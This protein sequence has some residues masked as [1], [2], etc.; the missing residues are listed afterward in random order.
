MKATRVALRTVAAVPA[1]LLVLALRSGGVA[2]AAGPNITIEHTFSGSSTSQ[3]TPTFTGMTNDILDTVTLK[4]YAGANATGSPVQSSTVLPV[5]VRLLARPTEAT[6]TVALGTALRSGQ[7]T[8]LAEQ[9]SPF[10]H[11]G[12]SPIVTFTVNVTP[13]PIVIAAPADNAILTASRPTFSGTAGQAKGD[14]QSVA[15]AIYSGSLVSGSPVAPPLDV[16]AVGGAWTTGSAGP[17]LADGIYTAQVSQSDE[18][19]NVGTSTVTF[20]I[21]APVA[22]GSPEAS[23][24]AAL[25]ATSPSTTSTTSSSSPSAPTA[26]FQWF[27]ANPRT[28]ERVV[29]AST[30][31]DPDSAISGFAWDLTGAGTFSAAGSALSTSFAAPGAHVVRLRITDAHGLSSVATRTIAVSAAPPKLM[32]PFPVVRIA[33]TVTALRVQVSLLSVQAPVGATVTVTCRGSGCPAAAR[34]E[35]ATSTRTGHRTGGVVLIVFRR[36]DRA[37]RAGASLQIRVSEPGQIGKYTR[38]SIRRAKLPVRVDACLS[39]TGTAP[40]VCPV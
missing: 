23:P 35:V 4:V 21:S 29:V 5:P 24:A 37:L 38:F 39:P 10:M 22:G 32:A 28:G 2:L 36:F 16:T 1:V 26:S 3:Q 19:G 17:Q 8:A 30:S 27:P 20:A 12:K 9:A 31:T 11:T 18:L 14:R 33:D 34:D 13:P 40:I 15:L 25:T 6:W 7:Y